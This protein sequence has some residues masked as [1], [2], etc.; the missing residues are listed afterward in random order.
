MAFRRAYP[1]PGGDGWCPRLVLLA[2]LVCAS[3][4]AGEIFVAT[5]GS[6][7]TGDGSVDSPYRTLAHAIDQ[8]AGGDTITLRE[9]GYSG[10]VT[11]YTDNL[12]IRSHPDEWAIISAPTGNSSVASCIWLYAHGC[13]LVELEIVGG[14]HYAV[15]FERGGGLVEKCRALGSGRDC[16]K[17]VP[18]ADDVIIRSCEI[19]NSGVRDSSNAEGIDNVNAD[20]MLVQDCYIHDTATTGV[21]A[22]GGAIGCVF[23][24]CLIMNCGSSGIMLGQGTGEAYMDPVQNPGYYE[25]I[26]GVV[27]NCIIVNAG[28][29]GLAAQAA[30]RPRFYNNT[31]VD[32]AKNIFAGVYVAGAWHNSQD[33]LCEDAEFANNVVVLPSSS[34]RPVVF[35]TPDSLQGSLTMDRNRYF[36]RGTAG[37]YWDENYWTGLH[38]L[39]EWKAALG[40]DAASTEGDP[41]LD[42]EMHLSA[43]SPCIDAGAAAGGVLDDYDGDARSGAFDI[44]ADEYSPDTALPVPPTAGTIGTGGQGSIQRDPGDGGGGRSGCAAGLPSILPAALL[45]F[46]APRRRRQAEG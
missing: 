2:S 38:S 11:V 6:D 3:A 7:V 39:D 20:R 14:Y 4:G 25:N 34:S 9:G 19:C 10:G 32:V 18:D 17:V 33:I 40:V 23:E 13:S 5:G 37:E 45:F 12:T 28:A 15:K 16:I 27:R 41:G 22:K 21:Y 26:D 46:L 36:H 44:G 24:R 8:A 30:L 31:C 1:R 29:A 35:L 43:G 42:V